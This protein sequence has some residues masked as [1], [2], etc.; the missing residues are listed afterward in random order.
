MEKVKLVV[1]V[2]SKLIKKWDQKL[3]KDGRNRS[4]DIRRYISDSVIANSLENEMTPTY[5]ERS[6]ARGKGKRTNTASR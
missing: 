1:M 2:D 4:Q 5:F 6:A 3:D